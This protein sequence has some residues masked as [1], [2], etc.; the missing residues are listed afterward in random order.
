MN[1]GG[2]CEACMSPGACCTDLSLFRHDGGQFVVWK[3]D[4]P[5]KELDKSIGRHW[6]VPNQLIG[7]W[8][9]E[10]HNDTYVSYSWRCTALGE[11]GRCTVYDHRP[12]LCRNYR[13]GSS[14]LCVHYTGE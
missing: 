2:L 3:S 13:E 10:N 6:F 5:V 8:W 1:R 7:E 11:D 14:P 12:L 4:D 9:S